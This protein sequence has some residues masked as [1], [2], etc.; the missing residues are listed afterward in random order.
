MNFADIY[1]VLLL[2]LFRLVQVSSMPDWKM[3]RQSL[4]NRES[5]SRRWHLLA[6]SSLCVLRISWTI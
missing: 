5:V 1:N 6:L 3:T 4:I 2:V